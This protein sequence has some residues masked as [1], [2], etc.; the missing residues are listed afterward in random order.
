MNGS[1]L[2]RHRPAEAPKLVKPPTTVG[3]F[4]RFIDYRRQEG[5][6]GQAVAARYRPMRSNLQ[7][8]G[9]DIKTTEDAREFM[10]LLRSRQAPRPLNQSLTM[11]KSFGRWAVSAGHLAEN[12]YSPI[13]PVKGA[14]PVQ[15]RRPFTRDEVIAFLHA[16]S[17]H[18]RLCWYTDFCLA[19]FSLGL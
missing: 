11:L 3:L 12:P 18:K 7:R 9:Q 4:E 5:T 13:K 2:E 6:S 15:N 1:I 17:S 8:F 16:L 14:I 19:L 10:E